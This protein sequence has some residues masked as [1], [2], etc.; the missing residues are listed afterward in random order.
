M[1]SLGMYVP[2][3]SLGQCGEALLICFVVVPD[4]CHLQ[5]DMEGKGV[6][7]GWSK[8]ELG[9]FLNAIRFLNARY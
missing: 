5:D 2:W 4:Q 3:E 7:G 9:K 8:S 6:K 1:S